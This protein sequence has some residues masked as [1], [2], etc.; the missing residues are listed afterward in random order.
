MATEVN[1]KNEIAKLKDYSFFNRVM[2]LFENNKHVNSIFVN[3]INDKE[4]SD[5][6]NCTNVVFDTTN[7]CITIGDFAKNGIYTS[8]LIKS[9]SDE[10][11]RCNNFFLITDDTIPIGTDIIYKLISDSGDVVNITANK[12]VPLVLQSNNEAKSFRLKV[13]L[14]SNGI[15]KPKIN[16]IAVM[17]F[18]NLVDAKLNLREPDIKGNNG[19]PTISPNHTHDNYVVKEPGKGLSSNDYTDYEK[20]LLSTLK[21]YEHPATHNAS[22]IIFSDNENLQQK[23]EDGDFTGSDGHSVFWLDGPEDPLNELGKYG[24][25]YIN[26]TNLDIFYKDESSNNWIKKVNMIGDLQDQVNLVEENL[27]AISRYLNYMPIN[28]GNFED[29]DGNEN[30]NISIDGGMY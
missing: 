10:E 11:S 25:W 21:N 22:M 9:F 29:I 4:Y 6:S 2:F 3:E 8:S 15:N 30:I 7:A 14:K 24:D 1:V 26:T 19:K 27:N 12:N 16:S 28:G 18:D 20:K 17:Y 13:E 5:F 23:F